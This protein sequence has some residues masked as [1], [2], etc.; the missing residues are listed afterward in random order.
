MEKISS[1]FLHQKFKWCHS[2]RSRC[3]FELVERILDLLN[4]VDA[5]PTQIH[6][7]QVGENIQ[8]TEANV[9]VVINSLKTG[10]TPH[11][12]DIRPEVLKTMNMC[13]VCWLIRV[14][15]V[16]CKTG[17]VPKQWQT[18]VKIPFHKKGDKRKCSN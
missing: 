2:E 11:E 4:P 6:V 8:I 15:K 12:D 5:T 14:C 18:S 9:N 16:A 3:Y 17:Q 10:K 7:E 13:G 1:R